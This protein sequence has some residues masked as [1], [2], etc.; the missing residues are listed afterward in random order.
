MSAWA[1][2]ELL[3]FSCLADRRTTA[4]SGMLNRAEEEEGLSD[5]SKKLGPVRFGPK[6]HTLCAVDHTVQHNAHHA[7]LPTRVCQERTLAAQHC[8]RYV[9]VLR[10]VALQKKS[11]ASFPMT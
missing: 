2:C 5:D 4:E 6:A 1:G 7:H 9:Y 11:M 10:R 8:R 3:F